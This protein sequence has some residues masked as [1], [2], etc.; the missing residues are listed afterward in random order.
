MINFCREQEFMVLPRVG[1]KTAKLISKYRNLV[2]NITAE[3][4]YEI[5][6]MNVTQDL[7]EMIDFTP[8]SDYDFEEQYLQ[9]GDVSPKEDSAQNPR[10][11][12]GKFTPEQSVKEDPRELQEKLIRVIDQRNAANMRPVTTHICYETPR[13]SMKKPARSLNGTRPK[14]IRTMQR[15]DQS[16]ERDF[17]RRPS[18]NHRRN[19][20]YEN[21]QRAAYSPAGTPRRPLPDYEYDDEDED[22]EDE[23]DDDE[24]DDGRNDRRQRNNF[25]PA[26]LPK[27]LTY[28]GKTNWLAFKRK[29]IRYAAASKWTE[30]ECLDALCWCLTGKAS[31]YFALMSE[32]NQDIS[33]FELLATLEKRFGAQELPETLYAKFSQAMQSQDEELED[34]A[35]RI[36]T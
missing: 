29:F 6:K 10:I 27:S 18:H 13:D 21:R 30:E 16:E 1:K 3:N 17:I 31:D 14:D 15:R 35:D 36:Q 9:S 4:I 26:S 11:G 33:Y 34:W 23:D 25:K 5:K 20:V 28:D 2:G 22:G 7:L 12:H 8:N 32:R 24:Y 19:A